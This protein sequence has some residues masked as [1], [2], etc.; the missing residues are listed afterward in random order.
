MT[1]VVNIKFKSRGKAYYFSPG[2]LSIK[3]GQSVIVETSKGL[4]MGECTGGNHEVDDGRIVPPLRP[5]VRIAT[6]NDARCAQINRTRE[7][8]AFEVC[9]KKI[10][11]HGLDMK[12]VDVECNFEGSKIMFFFT[13][14]GRVDFRELVKDL[15]A[16]CKTRIELRQIGVRDETKM[17]GGIGICGRPYC[18]KQFLDDFQP[19]STKMAKIQSMSLNPAKISGS[20]GRLMCCLRYEHEAYEDLVKKVP[21]NG[22][23]VRTPAGYGSVAQVNL[24]RRKVKVRLDTEGDEVVIKQY[25]ADEIAPVP[26]G[27]PKNGEDMPE[28]LLPE[29]KEDEF[30][31]YRDDSDIIEF[32]EFSETFAEP[33]ATEEKPPVRKKPARRKNGKKRA[34]GP[35]EFSKKTS[36]SKAQAILRVDGAEKSAQTQSSD[37]NMKKNTG[38]DRRKLGKAKN[39]SG[40]TAG[41]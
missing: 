21:K 3:N 1:Q 4:E 15:A 10:N 30:S 33:G 19:V 31:E 8:E 24:L 34:E 29:E 39:K 35:T 6:D 26:G 20:C 7:A 41:K 16:V 5:V 9:R 36:V 37:K 27:R 32:E 18:C 22:T 14:E 23:F 13:S 38:A 11:E 28:V 2:G 25:D 12:L 40:D 17:L